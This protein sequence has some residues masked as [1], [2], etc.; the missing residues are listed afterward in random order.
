MYLGEVIN[1][2]RTTF[3]GGAAGCMWK[4]NNNL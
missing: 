1:I 4:M 2:L 3:S